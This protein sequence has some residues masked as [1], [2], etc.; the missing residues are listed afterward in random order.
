MTQLPDA[1]G[2]VT[3]RFLPTRYVPPQRVAH[4]LTTRQRVVLAMLE[5]SMGGLALREMLGR[6]WPEV[7]DWELEAD[8]AFL[9]QL[10]LVDPSGRGRGAYWTLRRK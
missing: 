5:A 1:G 8:L 3:V 6:L 7:A 2:C 9:K 4:D 10:E